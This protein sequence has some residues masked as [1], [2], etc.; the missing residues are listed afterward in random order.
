M[1]TKSALLVHIIT[2]NQG[3][4][5]DLRLCPQPQQNG[6]GDIPCGAE[7]VRGQSQERFEQAEHIRKKDAGVKH[8]A[9]VSGGAFVSYAILLNAMVENY[10]K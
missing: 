3:L 8:S 10:R 5:L 1:W 7:I 9:S 4:A 2:R 6:D